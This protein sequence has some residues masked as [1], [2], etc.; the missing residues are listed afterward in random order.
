M[1]SPDLPVSSFISVCPV[2]AAAI[3]VYR[4]NGTT[5]VVALLRRAFDYERIRA[6]IWYVPTLL[7]LPGVYAATYAVM[8][9]RGLPLPTVQVPLLA[10]VVW[11]L[12]FFTAGQCEELGWSGYALD[13]LQERWTALGASLL[14]GVVWVAFH[15]VTLVQ[16]HR[17][18]EW[19]A[20][21]ALATLALRVLFTWL[22]INSS[23]NVFATVIFHMTG[24]LAQ[25]GPFL[26]FSP[27]G[28]PLVAQRIAAH[29]GGG[30]HYR[31]GMGTADIDA[32]LVGESPRRL[33]RYCR[34]SRNAYVADR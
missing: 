34:C 25:I 11:A 4:E 28:Y 20:W 5:G 14:L 31:F 13:P 33:V 24:I 6:K 10:A 26:D 22:Y 19:I 18:P 3:L 30:D 16:A 17:A 23:G 12:G 7:L 9:A 1:L 8:R 29:R 15:L 2:I 32:E 21:W 27:G